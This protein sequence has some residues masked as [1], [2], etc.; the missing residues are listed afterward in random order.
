MPNLLTAEAGLKL[1]PVVLETFFRHY[2]ER[3]HVNDKNEGTSSQEDMTRKKDLLWHEAFQIVKS[4]LNQASRHTVE[5]LQE[6]SNARIPAPPWIFVQRILIPRTVCDNAAIHLIKSFGGEE[7]TSSVVGGTKWWQV[8]GLDGVDCQWICQ[9]SHIQSRRRHLKQRTSRLGMNNESGTSVEPESIAYMDNTRCILYAHGDLYLLEPPPG[10][11][12]APLRPESIIIAGDS[13]GGG[14]CLALLQIIRDTG[15]PRPSGAVLISPWCDLTHSFPSTME[16]TASD[17][18]PPYGLCFHKPS[19]LWPPPPVDM[20]SEIRSEVRERFQTIFKQVVKTASQWRGQI[21]S[22]QGHHPVSANS[23][24]VPFESADG[25]GMS[26][27]LPGPQVKDAVTGQIR[28]LNVAGKLPLPWE[29]EDSFFVSVDGQKLNMNRQIQLYCPNNL[30]IH[31]LISPVLGYLGG[32][33]PLF[34]IAGEKEVLKD[35]IIYL[36]HKAA[37][38][39]KYVIH[40]DAQRIYPNYRQLTMSPTFVHLQIYD[41]NAKYCYRAVAEFIKHFATADDPFPLDSQI[42]APDSPIPAPTS[43]L[44]SAITSQGPRLSPGPRRHRSLLSLM[45]ISHRKAAIISSLGDDMAL[46]RTKAELPRTAGDAFFYR[47][48]KEKLVPGNIICERVTIHGATHPWNPR[49]KSNILDFPVDNLG[50]INE[51]AARRFLSGQAKWKERFGSL[52]EKIDSERRKNLLLAKCEA[53]K[54]LD[55]FQGRLLQ[56]E[57]NNK[58]RNLNDDFKTWVWSWAVDGERPPAS[59]IVSRRDTA[60]ARLLARIADQSVEQQESKLSGNRL[61]TVLANFLTN[62]LSD[63]KDME[64]V[65]EQSEKK[66]K[67]KIS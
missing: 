15:L 24:E 25:T 55:Q 32:L 31:P 26:A 45:G 14:L 18:I 62:R 65:A 61:W 35:E 2:L 57:Y 10:A 11:H 58:V 8:R 54:T 22:L 51:P 40:E 67:V 43:S 53:I 60:E 30:L 12:H 42:S 59:S 4:F 20:T 9:K 6:F 33:P 27:H 5:E 7:I 29:P 44:S 41:G 1:G 38:P 46:P 64:D 23:K 52:T 3:H 34:I 19:V 17:I 50:V 21:T 48:I 49:D 37:H 28:P 13:A 56:N 16:N 39:H 63:D 66:T 47:N 36:A